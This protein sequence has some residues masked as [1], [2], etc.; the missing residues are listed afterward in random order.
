M[1]RLDEDELEPIYN[2]H[3]ATLR[4][5]GDIG[6]P[7]ALTWSTEIQPSRVFRRGDLRPRGPLPPDY[8]GWRG[9]SP[10][11]HDFWGWTATLDEARS[12]DAHL[13]ELINTF[14]HRIDVLRST[15]PRAHIDIFAG[16]RTNNYEGG[17][18]LSPDTLCRLGSL[19]IHAGFS[20]IVT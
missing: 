5:V 1:S 11:P 10:A 8:R 18:D 4:V 19:G 13:R 20:V 7:D 16:Y 9:R 15:A 12:L 3:S 14:E 17:F 2:A 6:D